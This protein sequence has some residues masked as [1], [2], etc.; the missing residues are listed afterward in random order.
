M[1]AREEQWEMTL[2]NS[3]KF[4]TVTQSSASFCHL[5]IPVNMDIVVGKGKGE[6][7]FFTDGFTMEK[8]RK[9]EMN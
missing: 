6:K 8:L 4:Y 3:S 5:F 2:H 7:Q 9:F 1:G